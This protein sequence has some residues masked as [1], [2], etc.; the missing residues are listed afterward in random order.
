MKKQILPY[1]LFF[2]IIIFEF[3]LFKRYIQADIINFYPANFDQ[4]SFLMM[5]Y[6]V[7]SSTKQHGLYYSLINSPILATGILFPVQ[8]V[9]FF[10]ATGASRFYA[11]FLN[12]SYFVALQTFIFFVARRFFNSFSMAFIFLGLLLGIRF[13]FLNPGGVVDFRMDFM[14]FCIFGIAITSIIKSH[15]FLDTRWTFIST[16]FCILTILMRTITVVYFAG[17]IFIF[18]AYLCFHYYQKSCSF[19]E[20]LETKQRIKNI[21][22]FSSILTIVIIPI[23]L[24]NKTALYN[25]YVVGHITGKEKYIREAITGNTTLWKNVIYYPKALIEYC[26]GNYVVIYFSVLFFLL[27]FFKK[28]SFSVFISD[29]NVHTKFRIIIY[30]LSMSIVI[31]MILLTLDL[32]KSTIVAGVLI[33]PLLWLIIFLCFYFSKEISPPIRNKI[34]FIIAGITLLLGCITQLH[35]YRLKLTSEKKH[36]LSQLT[37]MYLTIGN[38][39]VLHHWP[40]VKLSVDC[41]DDQLTSGDLTVLYFEKKKIFLNVAIQPLGGSIFSISKKDAI[42]S[43]KNSNVAIFDLRK[44]LDHSDFP[45]TQ[46]INKIKPALIDYLYRNF[47]LLKQYHIGQHNYGVFVK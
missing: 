22:F 16:L 30:F 35:G 7:V 42:S 4:Q 21:L 36:E 27:T 11:L 10:L 14:A 43:L 33:T 1:F 38:Y 6:G 23:L 46:S 12:F 34:L 47:H 5:I 32:Q 26:L 40:T 37:Q 44:Q 31:P 20:R 41:I 29:T 9:V 15:I 45:L 8:A 28:R 25:Y 24:L 18:L 39:A 13:T 17:T 2:I 3:I 19:L